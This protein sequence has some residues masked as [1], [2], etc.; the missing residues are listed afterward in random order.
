M[1]QC[2]KYITSIKKCGGS[3]ALTGK[4]RCHICF[5]LC[6]EARLKRICQSI[7]ILLFGILC[8]N[9]HND[10][11]T[12]DAGKCSLCHTRLPANDPSKSFTAKI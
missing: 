9:K 2:K 7:V 4:R 6:L 1:A 12:E 8:C 5:Y 3:I 10:I 11:S